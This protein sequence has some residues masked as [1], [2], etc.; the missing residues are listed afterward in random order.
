ML[1]LQKVRKHILQNGFE[2][3]NR[4]IPQLTNGHEWPVVE[5]HHLERLTDV[6]FV[7][8]MTKKG[9]QFQNE[10]DTSSYILGRLERLRLL[11]DQGMEDI[12]QFEDDTKD[13]SLQYHESDIPFGI[14]E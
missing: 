11:G 8:L 10:D 2:R 13:E 14:R 3:I 4:K 12:P 6:E 5:I 1:D 9:I 7:L